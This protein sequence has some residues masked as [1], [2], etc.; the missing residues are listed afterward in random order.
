MLTERF[1]WHG[2]HQYGAHVQSRLP[3]DGKSQIRRR[4]ELKLASAIFP[5]EADG[6]NATFPGTRKNSG[7]WI[8]IAASVKSDFESAYC[9]LP[10]LE[11]IGEIAKRSRKKNSFTVRFRRVNTIWKRTYR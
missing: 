1:T 5:R 8:G 6:I 11:K 7:S 4:G 10:D 3:E 2:W 9:M